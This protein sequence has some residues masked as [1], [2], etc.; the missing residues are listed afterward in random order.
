MEEI[1]KLKIF[2]IFPVLYV[3]SVYMAFSNIFTGNKGLPFILMFLSPFISGILNIIV[4]IRCCKPQYHDIMITSA[5]I[6]KYCMIPFFVIGGFLVAGSFI[7]GIILPIPPMFIV[8]TSIA[9]ILCIAGWLVVAFGSPYTISYIVL[10]QKAGRTSKVM[11]VLHIV[12]QFFFTMD[13]IDV[14]CLSFKAKRNIKM[15]VTVIVLIAVLFLLIIIS[16]LFIL[17][18]AI[19][20]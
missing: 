11:A 19:T 17:M 20:D 13:V 12:L 4:C 18:Q 15:S 2:Y 16:F 7:S 10:S 1:K 9:F 6:I 8:G 14:I 3:L 5:A